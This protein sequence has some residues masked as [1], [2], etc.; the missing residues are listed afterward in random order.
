[1]NKSSSIL[2]LKSLKLSATARDISKKNKKFIVD[3]IAKLSEEAKTDLVGI[4]KEWYKN[5][6]ISYPYDDKHVRFN[7]DNIPIELRWVVLNFLKICD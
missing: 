3:S 2:L 5:E 6:N 7:I 4:L 1:M